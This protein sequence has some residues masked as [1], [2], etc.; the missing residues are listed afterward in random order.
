MTQQLHLEF[1]RKKR[2]DS[3][4][5][6]VISNQQVLLKDEIL[7]EGVL[8]IV[9]NGEY[10]NRLPNTVL[11][12]DVAVKILEPLLWEDPDAVRMFSD[13]AKK[14]WEIR[15]RVKSNNVVEPLLVS[16][17]HVKE[18]SKIISVPFMVLPLYK[19]SV[20][21][22]KNSL[23]GMQKL[24][25][26]E[27]VVNGLAEVLEKSKYTHGDLHPGNILFDGTDFAIGDF[28]F[29]NIS[30]LAGSPYIKKSEEK[31]AYVLA[32]KMPFMDF[33]FPEKKLELDSKKKDVYS[34][35]ANVIYL[36]LEDIDSVGTRQHY[37]IRDFIKD[38]KTKEGYKKIRKEFLSKMPQKL[39]F[40]EEIL[41]KSFT[42]DKNIMFN[43]AI[44]L[45]STIRKL[46]NEYNISYDQDYFLEKTREKVIIEKRNEQKTKFR[47]GL[48]KFLLGLTVTALVYLPIIFGVLHYKKQLEKENKEQTTEQTEQINQKE[49][50]N[51]KENITILNIEDF[52]EKDDKIY[53]N[54]WDFNKSVKFAFS[55]ARWNEI[56]GKYKTNNGELYTEKQ[57]SLVNIITNSV[58]DDWEIGPD[59]N[60]KD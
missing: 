43:D 8:G 18:D 14:N 20:L 25:F 55:K 16:N 17:F 26:L 36:F 33:F 24:K 59:Y 4:K 54:Y 22:L 41:E 50:D 28:G 30:E 48:K 56:V 52:L 45:R 23:S 44:E 21:K 39:S 49:K 10:I 51:K 19:G 15:K 37:S 40:L 29:A 60:N 2:I 46:W 47:E 35:G 12:Q 6:R 31:S 38:G 58:L 34:F 42:P 5:N 3:L 1:R 57:K 13:E 53:L 27:D 7:G 11:K 9:L 32:S